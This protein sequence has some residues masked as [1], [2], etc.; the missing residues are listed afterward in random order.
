[1]SS[2]RYPEEFKIE[3]AVRKVQV[4]DN[5]AWYIGLK[6]TGIEDYRFLFC[7]KWGAG[8]A[9]RWYTDMHIWHQTI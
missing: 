2:K 8:K 6:K 9:L 7:R 3:A 4:N 5:N 1:M